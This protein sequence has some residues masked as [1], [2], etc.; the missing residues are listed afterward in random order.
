ML[1]QKT[2]IRSILSLDSAENNRMHSHDLLEDD[3]ERIQVG[4]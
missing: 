3:D 1:S 4:N 2:L